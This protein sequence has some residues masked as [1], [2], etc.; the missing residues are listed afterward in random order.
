[1]LTVT[2]GMTYDRLRCAL[3]QGDRYL[4]RAGSRGEPAVSAGKGKAP[5][6]SMALSEFIESSVAVEGTTFRR[7][8][9]YIGRIAEFRDGRDWRS[10]HVIIG[11]RW[12][13]G[14][15]TEVLSEVAAWALRQ[16]SIFRI[17]AVCDVENIG[18]ARVLEKS[19]FV[20][21]GVL[22]RWLV[23]PNISDEPRDCY[24]YSRVR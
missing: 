5:R 12:R 4:R 16:R 18:S 8:V 11:R 13:Q 17:G 2:R 14:L 9:Q 20:R 15:M 6:G 24:N 21:E 10:L 23:H 1:L 3:S 19:G 22:R 7:G